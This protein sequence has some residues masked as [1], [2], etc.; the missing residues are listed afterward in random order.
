MATIVL[1]CDYNG[2]N[3]EGCQNTVKG[4]LEKAGNTVEN[5]GIAPG[6]FADYSYSSK[7]SGKI[8][9]Y[10]MADS[11]VSVADLA[12]GNTSFKYAYFGIRGDL[13]LPRMSSRSDFENN[14]IGRDADC[15]SICDKLAHKTY[16]EMNEIIKDKAHIVFGTTPEEIGNEIVKAMG[17]EADNDKSKKSSASSIKE[18]LKKVCSHWDGDVEIRLI[19]DTV[20]VN[21]IDDPTTTKILLDE[22]SNVHYDSV[23]VTDVNPDTINH[24]TCNYAGYDLVLSDELLI[25]RFGKNAQVVNVDS[26][27]K[28]LDDAEVFLQRE[29]NKIRRDDGRSVELKVEG[30]MTFNSGKWCRV[31]LPSF[32]VDDYMYIS[33]CSHEEDGSNNWV[34]SLTLVD[35]PPSFGAEVVENENDS[36]ENS[37]NEEDVGSTDTEEVES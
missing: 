19:N 5:L 2:V 16:P 26:N 10:L 4:I 7:A 32:F 13:G 23:N 1:G 14:P 34:T 8:G 15:T 3:D 31:Y 20:Y 18:S 29:W 33:K 22:N 36:D 17:G 28:S 6:P 37:L 12:L 9:V 27:V 11:L 35:Y 25:S 30:D 21:R 24:L